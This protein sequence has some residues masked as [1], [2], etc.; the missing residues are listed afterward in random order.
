[1]NKTRDHATILRIVNPTD[2]NVRCLVLRAAS[3][4]YAMLLFMT[5]AISDWDVE[6]GWYAVRLFEQKL[7]IAEIAFM[8]QAE[9]A[10]LARYIAHFLTHPELKAELMKRAAERWPQDFE[11]VANIV[12]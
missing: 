1:L 9:Q 12:Y 10:W 4:A 7:S 8:L 11:R 2:F 3:A 6:H 5:D